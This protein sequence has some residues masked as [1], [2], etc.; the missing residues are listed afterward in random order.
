MT[1]NP[2]ENGNSFVLPGKSVSLSTVLKTEHAQIGEVRKLRLERSG[3]NS[4]EFPV[5][6]PRLKD[7]ATP[8]KAPTP[9][10][11]PNDNDA[12]DWQKDRDREQSEWRQAIR[13]AHKLNLAGLCFSGGGIRSAT[14][15]LGVLQA[16][17][18]LKLLHRID[19]LSTVSGG[20]YIGSWLAAWT[21]RVGNFGK[22]QQLLSTDRVHLEDD[23]E[24]API[25]FLRTYSNYLTPQLGL[26]SG[27]TLA[28]VA[29]YLR[30]LLL[31]Q[32]VIIGLLATLLLVPRVLKPCAAHI[33]CLDAGTVQGVVMAAEA[34]LLIVVL[35]LTTLN[36]ARVNLEKT[37]TWIDQG[38]FIALLIVS[39]FSAALLAGVWLWLGPAEKGGVHSIPEWATAAA[40][41]VDRSILASLTRHLTSTSGLL[42]FDAMRGGILYAAIWGCAALLGLFWAKWFEGNKAETNSAKQTP[43]AATPKSQSDPH[44]LSTAW[45]VLWQTIV[46]L[47]AALATG[48]FAGWLYGLLAH[49]VDWHR[50]KDALTFGVPL[51]VGIVLLAATLHIGLLGTGFKDEKR[52][53]WGRLGGWL[54]AIG[55]G[56]LALFWVALYFPD[57]VKDNKLLQQTVQSLAAKY[58]TPAWILTTIGSVLAGNSKASGK[59][60]EKSTTETYLDLLAE[61]GPYVFIAGLVCWMSWGLSLLPFGGWSVFG[62]F[63]VCLGLTVLMSWRVDINQFSM[64]MFYRN[65]L[66]GCYLGA[67]NEERSPNLFTGFDPK[68]DL[69]LKCFKSPNPEKDAAKPSCCG[70]NEKEYDG[71]YPVL[72]MSLNLVKGKDLAWQER[73]AESF[74]MT[75][76]YCG[77]DV[78]LEQQYSKMQSEA[79]K[80]MK[81]S[82]GQR[83]DLDLYGYRPTAEY[84]FPSPFHGPNLGLAMAISGAAASPNMGYYTSTPVAFLLT[85]FNVRL[86]QWL[87]NPRNRVTSGEPTPR[88][89]LRCLMQE[90]FAGTNDTSDYVYLSDGGHFDNMGLYELVKRRCGLIIVCD[91]EADPNYGFE[92]LG[93][94]I[95]RCRID[96]GISIEI[97]TKPIVP[98]KSGMSKQHYAI[99]KIHYEQADMDAPVGKII[100]IKA[101]LTGEEPTDVTTYKKRH[102]TFPHESTA[103]QWFSESQFESYRRLGYAALESSVKGKKEH[104]SGKVKSDVIQILKEFG[105]EIREPDV[106]PVSH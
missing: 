23:I 28:M 87:G 83:G 66:V 101:S 54:I 90:L 67:S 89:G 76:H 10:R 68:D 39:L 98:N 38:R 1:C 64:H 65:R 17:A 102:R 27:D 73:K 14:F 40:T 82:N 20:G 41:A 97:D 35:L 84:A 8:P 6:E 7:V 60:G 5:G 93:N 53:W 42:L 52:E 25:R 86:G 30:N 88:V 18:D 59:P 100:Y 79:F 21:K 4:A 57:F 61:V 56:W 94:A 32:S 85:V 15:N 106:P 78:F 2:D 34:V 45:R 95:K 80:E 72:N 70:E 9:G 104:G 71:P 74:V 105:F 103:D 22:V 92:G 11:E 51:V 55:I 69:A 62:E 81:A 19:Y 26:F 91:V 49:L 58:L 48:A 29:I 75:P 99:G 12:P 47:P 33:G 43:Q 50:A 44:L 13:D 37:P 24:S 77:F 3:W 31:N 16:L 63:G 96:L 46:K 36:L